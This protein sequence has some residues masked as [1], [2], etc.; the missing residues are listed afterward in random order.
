MSIL[1]PKPEHEIAYQDLNKLIGKHGDRVSALEMFAIASN[2]LG[3]LAALQ[4]QRTVTQKIL[5]DI[6]MKNFELGN[7]QAVAELLNAEGGNA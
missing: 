1:T 4:D 6:L 5:I 2:L 7:Q 3:K